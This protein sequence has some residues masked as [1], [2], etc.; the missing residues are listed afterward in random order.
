MGLNAFTFY[1]CYYYLVLFTM[2]HFRPG[3]CTAQWT[4]MFTGTITEDKNAQIC[5]SQD[6]GQCSSVTIVIVG[7][8]HAGFLRRVVTSHNFLS[9]FFSFCMKI[10][11]L[12]SHNLHL[13]NISSQKVSKKQKF[14][15]VFDGFLLN[16]FFN[17]RTIWDN[18]AIYNK[19]YLL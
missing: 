16:L 7:I 14:A 19:I 1:Y 3:S 6:G 2:K 4:Q 15:D 10:L 8:K 11:I 17:H 12:V 5:W 9:Y 18:F 13:R